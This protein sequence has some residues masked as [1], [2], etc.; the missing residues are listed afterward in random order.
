M[1]HAQP[2]RIPRSAKAGTSHFALLPAYATDDDNGLPPAR[3]PETP[4]EISLP[5]PSESIDFTLWAKNAFLRTCPLCPNRHLAPWS[6]ESHWLT[7]CADLSWLCTER[8]PS[9]LTDQT[10]VMADAPSPLPNQR[11]KPACDAVLRSS[12]GSPPVLAR[13]V[14]NMFKVQPPVH[15]PSAWSKHKT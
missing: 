9:V 8:T 2:P 4:T 3:P 10:E 15:V 11:P 12:D 7:M 14:N 6:Q 5:R 13:D 1:A